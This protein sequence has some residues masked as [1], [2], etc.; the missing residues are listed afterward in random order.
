MKAKKKKTECVSI[1]AEL[2]G[3]ILQGVRVYRDPAA[4]RRAFKRVRAD[5]EKR[6]VLH[7]D[8]TEWE[9]Y[10]GEDEQTVL[11]EG[12]PIR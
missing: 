8:C 2:Y 4:A 1:L 9:A 11:W 10:D 7:P 6:G 12:I 5:M 3:G